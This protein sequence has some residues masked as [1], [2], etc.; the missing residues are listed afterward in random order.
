LDQDDNEL[1][2]FGF[3]M[4]GW[5][6]D[7]S[8]GDP[9]WFLTGKGN[10]TRFT[11][12]MEKL[13]QSGF[14]VIRIP[15]AVQAIQEWKVGNET[16]YGVVPC[17]DENFTDCVAPHEGDWI[18]PCRMWNTAQPQNTKM[19]QLEVYLHFIHEAGLKFFFDFHT[20]HNNG[21]AGADVKAKE[22]MWYD[23]GENPIWTEEHWIDSIT[24]L[25]DRFKGHPAMIGVDLA[26]E[27]HGTC[28]EIDSGEVGAIW[29]ESDEPNNYKRFIERAGNAAHAVDPDLLIIVAGIECFEGHNANWGGNLR[30]VKK[31][32]INLAIPNKVVYS[33]HEYGPGVSK[34][35]WFCSG[36]EVNFETLWKLHFYLDWFYIHD[37]NIAPILIGEWGQDNTFPN[38]TTDIWFNSTIW[39]IHE[40]N[41]SQTYWA[42]CQFD[43]YGLITWPGPMWNDPLIERMNT[44]PEQ[45][46]SSGEPVTKECIPELPPDASIPPA[47]GW[48]PDE[49]PTPEE[50][51]TPPEETPTAPD[52]TPTAPDETPTAPAETPTA[53]EE[54]PSAP[55]E[56]PTAPAETP[57]APAETPTAPE[58]TPTAPTGTPTPPTK[59]APAPA[60]TPTTA[61]KTPTTPAK[62]PTPPDA[63]ATTRDATG[64]PE[65]ETPTL[66]P[67]VVTASDAAPTSRDLPVN[68]GGNDAEQGGSSVG[69]AVGGSLAGLAALAGLLLLFLLLK[70]KKRP[71][72]PPE[73]APVD[74]TD[75]MTTMDD[76]G[77][78]S[79]YGLSDHAHEDGGGDYPDR[80]PPLGPNGADDVRPP[81]FLSEYGL[82]DHGRKRQ[83]PLDDDDGAPDLP[84]SSEGEGDQ[85]FLSE[86]G[87]SDDE[88]HGKSKS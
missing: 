81:D 66:A 84:N 41:L 56:T 29:D 58:E 75:D 68:G 34:S 73:E 53:P 39:L 59:S 69:A 79:E 72:V 57:A 11:E 18:A 8:I 76:P 83:D 35:T 5:E 37:E 12:N 7:G 85:E 86:Y 38:S 47:P 22:K 9:E 36:E 4:N 21:F 52:E 49:E 15:V 23:T 61:A 55:A 44:K 45:P 40:Y 71:E 13:V 50:T 1:W 78:I 62:T 51:A 67:V 17:C 33:P 32:P 25:L 30:G 63:T 60:E 77:Y 42:I 43:T 10:L 27:R 65:P 28:E 88:K 54:T 46:T 48:N 24:W 80:E 14:N 6:A 82:S 31:Y 70:R 20:L 74:E 19:R 16:A 26:N 2:L 87:L 3:N 64:T